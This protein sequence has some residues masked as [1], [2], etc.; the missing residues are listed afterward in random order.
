M[1]GNNNIAFLSDDN[2]MF[3]SLTSMKVGGEREVKYPVNFHVGFGQE[4][5]KRV[6]RDSTND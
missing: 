6:K 2:G 1:G 4:S 3:L 5:E